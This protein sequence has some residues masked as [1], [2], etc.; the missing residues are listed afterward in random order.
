MPEQHTGYLFSWIHEI[1]SLRFHL[2]P[3]K[4]TSTGL[5]EYPVAHPYA[6]AWNTLRGVKIYFNKLA[7][8]EVHLVDSTGATRM[9]GGILRGTLTDHQS[10]QIPVG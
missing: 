1:V 6:G 8:S 3:D 5:S 2:T 7:P 4:S 10:E 9:T